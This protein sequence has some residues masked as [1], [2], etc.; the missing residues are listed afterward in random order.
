MKLRAESN[1]DL[2]PSSCVPP[3]TALRWHFHPAARSS[4]LLLRWRWGEGAGGDACLFRGA[5]HCLQA[6]YVSAELFQ[7]PAGSRAAMCTGTFW[8]RPRER[9][10]RGG[11]TM[12][13]SGSF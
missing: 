3:Q 4:S 7:W 8:H 1:S 10:W 2:T 9:K 11:G 5:Q 6:S 12:Y 13:E